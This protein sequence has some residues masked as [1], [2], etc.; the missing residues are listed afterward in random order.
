MTILYTLLTSALALFVSLSRGLVA[1][2]AIKDSIPFN[3]NSNDKSNLVIDPSPSNPVT[4][5]DIASAAGHVTGQTLDDMVY[6]SFHTGQGTIQTTRKR[7]DAPAGA[8]HRP[9]HTTSWGLH[10]LGDTNND[11]ST[12][13]TMS[14]SYPEIPDTPSTSPVTF[15]IISK[16]ACG[17][18]PLVDWSTLDGRSGPI[19]IMQ[20]FQDGS[21]FIVVIATR[22]YTDISR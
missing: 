21:V 2:G 22:S 12:T 17:D 16:H 7:A 10:R 20:S 8:S 13:L 1:P 3:L 4:F 15:Q 9:E 14:F 19:N 11:D 18:H 6:T 5:T